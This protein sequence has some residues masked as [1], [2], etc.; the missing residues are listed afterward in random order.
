M[1]LAAWQPQGGVVPVAGVRL[2]IS[3]NVWRRWRPSRLIALLPHFIQRRSSLT[4]EGHHQARPAAC[5]GGIIVSLHLFRLVLITASLHHHGLIL[6][7]ASLLHHSLIQ[8]TVSLLH[9]GAVL[10]NAALYLLRLILFT[11]QAKHSASSLRPEPGG[12]AKDKPTAGPRTGTTRNESGAPTWQG[13]AAGTM[14]PVPGRPPSAPQS[15]Q[16]N[17]GA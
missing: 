1:P 9:H 14:S 11:A 6:A 17:P 8:R 13:P 7:T 4:A 2:R 5:S 16:V 3:W 12:P 15:R 10:I